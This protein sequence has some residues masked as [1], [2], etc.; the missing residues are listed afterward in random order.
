MQ[1]LKSSLNMRMGWKKFPTSMQLQKGVPE[2]SIL[3]PFRLNNGF[4]DGDVLHFTRSA[5]DGGHCI[6]E[7]YAE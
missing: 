5:M 2:W 3:D 4:Y 7:G 1:S 6:V